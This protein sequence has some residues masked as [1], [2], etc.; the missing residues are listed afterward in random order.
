M[1]F[2]PNNYRAK[3]LNC[4]AETVIVVD[5]QGSSLW[6]ATEDGER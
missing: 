6:L 5:C 4:Q 2:T 1:Q 3:R